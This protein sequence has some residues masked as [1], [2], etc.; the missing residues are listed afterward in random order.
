[1]SARCQQDVLKL[2]HEFYVPKSID[3]RQHA[4]S[5]RGSCVSLLQVLRL[6]QEFCYVRVVHSLLL[7]TTVYGLAV[8]TQLIHYSFN[9]TKMC[10]CPLSGARVAHKCAYAHDRVNSM[11]DQIKTVTYA[12]R[13]F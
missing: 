6:G 11:Q 4:R 5:L 7:F 9:G 8:I 10:L 12:F 1:M 2:G 13:A 3:G